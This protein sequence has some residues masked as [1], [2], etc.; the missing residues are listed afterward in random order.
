MFANRSGKLPLIAALLASAA[1]SVASAD[2]L[3][4]VISVQAESTDEFGVTRSGTYNVELDFSPGGGYWNPDTQEYDWSLPNDVVITAGDG[5]VLGGIRARDPN[6]PLL[7]TSVYCREDPQVDVNFSV[8]AG[9][10]NTTFTITSP[11]L[12][13]ATLAN[14]QGRTSAGFSLTDLDGDGVS[15]SGW[16]GNSVYTARYNGAVPGG[17]TFNDHFFGTSGTPDPFGSYSTSENY[18]GVGFTPIGPDVSDMSSRFRFTLS[19]NDIASGTSVYEIIPV[20]APSAVALLGLGG[21]LVARRR[22]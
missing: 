3:G 13:F 1:A 6:N 5:T 12:S 9:S 19:A 21:L 18:P 7:R 14:T 10:L 8:F 4:Y 2:I 17:T 15:L 20:P 11:T 16:N 22:R